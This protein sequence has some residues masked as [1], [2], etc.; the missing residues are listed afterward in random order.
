LQVFTGTKIQIFPR[1]DTEKEKIK[2]EISTEY[3]K[4][5]KAYSNS[6]FKQAIAYYAIEK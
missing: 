1:T 5:H 3:L 4:W 2:Q 6:K